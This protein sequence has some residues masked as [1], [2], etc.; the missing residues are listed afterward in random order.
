MATSNAPPILTAD[1]ADALAQRRLKKHDVAIVLL[2]WFNATVWLSELTTGLALVTAPGLRV[3]PWW[4][5]NIV[6]GVFG[7]RANMLQFSQ[8]V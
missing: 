2:H 6:Q 7:S 1:Q 8:S 5:I 3:M 4:Y